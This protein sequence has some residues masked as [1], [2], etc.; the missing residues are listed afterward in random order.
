[1]Y[2][3]TWAVEYHYFLP[4]FMDKYAVLQVKQL[5]ESGVSGPELEESIKRIESASYNYKHS[6]FFF[7]L[8]TYMEILPVG[9]LITLISSLILKRKTPKNK[10]TTIAS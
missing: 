9:I 10:S 3:I 8:Y 2:V 4:D 7:T 1:M 6:A 5:T